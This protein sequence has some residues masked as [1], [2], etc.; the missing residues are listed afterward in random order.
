MN[1]LEEHSNSIYTG[2]QNIEAVCSEW[3]PGTHQSDYTAPNPEHY[4]FES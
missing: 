4:N 3:K 1:V 2:H